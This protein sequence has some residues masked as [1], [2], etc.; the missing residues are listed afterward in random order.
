MEIEPLHT[1]RKCHVKRLVKCEQTLG[2]GAT[3]S[4]VHGWCGASVRLTRSLKNYKYSPS[5]NLIDKTHNIITENEQ[6]TWVDLMTRQVGSFGNFRYDDGVIC[7]GRASRPDQI[8][9]INSLRPYHD[10]L[11]I[12]RLRCFVLKSKLRCD[13]TLSH[14]TNLLI[15]LFVYA[16][17]PKKHH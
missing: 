17:R 12:D 4:S 9:P 16:D 6:T 10:W 3:I 14:R 13:A 15:N 7:L 5:H 1:V 11:K 2:C 8:L